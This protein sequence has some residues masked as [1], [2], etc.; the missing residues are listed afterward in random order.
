MSVARL[1]FR[2]HRPASLLLAA[3]FVVSAA[4]ALR[5]SWDRVDEMLHGDRYVLPGFDLNFQAFEVIT[6]DSET[7]K[8]GLRK[9]DIV[10]G[11][12][13]RPAQGWSDLEVPARRARTG[14]HLLLRVKRRAGAGLLNRTSRF[15]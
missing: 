4:I 9:G 11:I 6:L 14:D 5:S 1:D 2:N 13:G 8:A 15:H 7:E 10:I 12:N 3:L